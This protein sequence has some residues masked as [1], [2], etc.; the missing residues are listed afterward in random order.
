MTTTR[1]FFRKALVGWLAYAMTF[2]PGTPARSRR[3]P[4]PI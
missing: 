3:C 2:G 1:M 4:T